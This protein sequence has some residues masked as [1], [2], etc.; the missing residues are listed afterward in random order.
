VD[1]DN[2]DTTNLQRQILYS[3]IDVGKKKAF[4]AKERLLALNPEIEISVYNQFLNSQNAISLINEH[5]LIVDGSDNFPCRYLV[6]DACVKT[7]KPFVSGAIFKFSGQVGVFNYKGS[8][9]YRCLFPEPPLPEDRPDCNET[10]VVGILPGLIGML[11]A[12]E[13]IKIIVGIGEV[14]SGKILNV[15]LLTLQFHSLSFHKDE[16]AVEKVQSAPLLKELQY[17]KFCNDF[18]GNEIIKEISPAAFRKLSGE[19]NNFQLIDVR[20][21]FEHEKANIGGELIPYKDIFLNI[22]NI[23]TDKPVILYC[24]RGMR[25][26]IAIQRLQEKYD[27]TNLYTLKGGINAYVEQDHS[28]A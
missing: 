22:E 23:A 3:T 15:D 5:D 8:G 26:H 25:S 16:D 28:H 18:S 9:T 20:E 13:V 17:Q 24:Q 2:I 21:P 27:F 10:G 7:G 6:N 12:N 14:L 4:A 1:G 11:M 19:G